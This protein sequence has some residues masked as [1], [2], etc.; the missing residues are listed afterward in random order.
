MHITTT[1]VTLKPNAFTKRSLLKTLELHMDA[2]ELGPHWK[3]KK[4]TEALLARASHDYVSEGQ[5]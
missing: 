3:L 5:S 4:Y 1:Q 2:G